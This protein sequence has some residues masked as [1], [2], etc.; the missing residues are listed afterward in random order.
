MKNI[1]SLIILTIILFGCGDYVR[2]KR[3]YIIKGNSKIVFNG[4]DKQLNNKSII[5]GF[6]VSKKTNEFIEN[7]F[8]KIGTQKIQT[9]KNGF[10]ITTIEPGIYSVSSNYIGNNEEKI[11]DLK[12]DKNNRLIIIFEL[13]TSVIQ[14]N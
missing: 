14:C 5:S 4:V 1:L 12:I 13:G 7:A 6:V 3:G 2:T 9:D 8:V 11:N 10:F